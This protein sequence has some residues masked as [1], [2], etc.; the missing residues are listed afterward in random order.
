MTQY[1]MQERID[2]ERARAD[3]AS[4]SSW[5]GFLFLM[6]LIYETDSHIVDLSWLWWVGGVIAALICICWIFIG[7]SVFCDWSCGLFK[8]TKE[9]DINRIRTSD[10]GV[11]D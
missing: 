4:S 7:I 10:L 3:E 9:S 1:E 5:W 11:D 6:I 8:R 2:M